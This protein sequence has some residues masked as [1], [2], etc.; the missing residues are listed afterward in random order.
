MKNQT[1]NEILKD[2]IHL[3]NDQPKDISALI[4]WAVTLDDEARAALIMAYRLINEK[5]G[6]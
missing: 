2:A 3:L 1:F 4:Y 6:E 5:D